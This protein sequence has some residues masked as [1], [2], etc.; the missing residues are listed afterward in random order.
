MT[1]P[2]VPDATVLPELTEN[3]PGGRVAPQS[4]VEISACTR[5]GKWSRD[6]SQ[7]G[8]NI[9]VLRPVGARVG[10]AA[11]IAT[12]NLDIAAQMDRRVTIRDDLVVELE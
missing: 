4:K 3:L 2:A 7:I 6:E 8:M 12:H 11:V 9:R 10:L 5:I 1:P